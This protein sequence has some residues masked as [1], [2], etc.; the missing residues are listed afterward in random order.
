MQNRMFP[1][2]P[3]YVPRSPKE[4]ASFERAWSVMY[5]TYASIMATTVVQFKDVPDGAPKAYDKH[6][7]SIAEYSGWCDRSDER[8]RPHRL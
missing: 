4:Q 1:G 3:E 8:A 2:H 7:A 5:S 6:H